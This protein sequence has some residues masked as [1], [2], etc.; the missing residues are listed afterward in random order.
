MLTVWE[1]RGER[2][3]TFISIFVV[4]EIGVIIGVC[5]KGYRS[6]EIDGELNWDL[7]GRKVFYGFSVYLS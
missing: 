7:G 6:K 2:L 3:V 5:I 4:Y 1:V